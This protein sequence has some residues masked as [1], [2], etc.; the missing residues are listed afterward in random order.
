[1]TVLGVFIVLVALGDTI[2]VGICSIIEKFSNTGSL[3]A[4]MGLFMVVFV[5]AWKLAV[6]ITERFFVRA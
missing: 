4:F 1:M 5:I 6:G 2:T 3:F